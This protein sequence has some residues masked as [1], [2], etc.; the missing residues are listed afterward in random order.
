MSKGLCPAPDSPAPS[1]AD[2]VHPLTERWLTIGF[3]LAV[4]YMGTRALV[5]ATLRPFWFDEVCTW[6]VVQQHGISGVWNA[7]LHTADGQPL[8]FYLLMKI[9]GFFIAKPE[10]ALRVPTVAAFC[11]VLL[12]AYV[13]IRTTSHSIIAWICGLFLMFSP[14]RG[15]YAT[16]ARP[17]ALVAGCLAL[18]LV[19]YQRTEHNWFVLLFGLSLGVA[20]TFHYYA[21]FFMVP[22][23]LAETTY[24]LKNKKWRAGVWLALCA[25]LVPLLAFVPLLSRLKAAQGTHFWAQPI[26]SETLNVY[27]WLAGAGNMSLPGSLMGKALVVLLYLSAIFYLA[28]RLIKELGQT[29]SRVEETAVLLGLLLSPWFMYVALK[30]VHGGLTVRYMVPLTVTIPLVLA[31]FLKFVNRRSLMVIAIGMFLMVTVLEISFWRDSY[32]LEKQAST[33]AQFLNNLLQEAGHPDLPVVIS[34]PVDYLSMAYYATPP[35]SARVV[36]P[37]DIPAELDVALTDTPELDLIALAPYFPINIPEYNDF[38]L[39]HPVFLL[40]AS[41]DGID[42]ID[43]WV[44]RFRHEHVDMKKVAHWSNTVIYLVSLNESHVGT[45]LGK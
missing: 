21:I 24:F 7:L 34:S 11:T 4:L 41:S 1:I 18:A 23:A 26:A 39:K 5:T 43:W 10:I 45:D 6:T 30:T 37:I 14:L 44:R 33:P 40:Y 15:Y 35:L 32:P 25:P 2:P 22:F 20:E 8:G 31:Q 38:R 27:A 12:C 16:E 19:F 13:W 3:V 36:E 42:R 29:N 9:P 28:A 17:Y